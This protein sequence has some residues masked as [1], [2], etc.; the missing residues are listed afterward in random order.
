M[1]RLSRRTPRKKNSGAAYIYIYISYG[2]YPGAHPCVN[3]CSCHKTN[4][5]W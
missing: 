3:N 4:A 2:A 5:Y 1:R